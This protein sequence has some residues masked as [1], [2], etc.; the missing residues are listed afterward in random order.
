MPDKELVWDFRIA[1]F[2]CGN[3]NEGALSVGLTFILW[4]KTKG[5]R[6]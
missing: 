4:A 6:Y 1:G 2:L 5:E 3:G